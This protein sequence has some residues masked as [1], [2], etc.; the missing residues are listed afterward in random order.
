MKIKEKI[1][2]YLWGKIQSNNVIEWEDLNKLFNS[3]KNQIGILSDSISMISNENEKDL[4][5]RLDKIIKQQLSGGALSFSQS[6]EDMVLKCLLRDMKYGFYI[7]IGAHHPFR[8]SNT[9]SFYLNG[10]RGINVDPIPGTMQHFNKVRPND[11]NLEL[12]VGNEGEEIYYMFDE[13]AYN[14]LDKNIAESLI[15]SGITNLDTKKIIRKHSLSDVLDRHMPPGMKIDFLTVDAE[16]M[17]VEILESNNW[18]KYKPTYVCAECHTT[19]KSR[20]MNPCETLE[21]KGY[22]LVA[23][24]EFSSIFKSE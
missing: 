15:E 4:W 11:I 12:A 24:T 7:D 2:K 9:F 8:F 5:L 21:S 17:D 3:N 19:D 22:R 20:S 18:D 16:G 10:W 1:K 6:G 14:T 23:S 13:P